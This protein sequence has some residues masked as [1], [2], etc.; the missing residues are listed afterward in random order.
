MNVFVAGASGAIGRPV[1]AEL[2][3]HRHNVT[4]LARSQSA[5]TDLRIQGVTVIE[6]DVFDPYSIRAAIEKARPDVVIDELTSLPKS[7]AELANAIP[8]DLKIRLEGGGNLHRAAEEF[9]VKRYLQQASGFFLKAAKGLADEGSPIAVEAGGNVGLSA[10]MYAE[11]E[12]RVRR[13]SMEGVALRYGFFYGPGT[14]YR[15]DGSAAEQVRRNETPIIGDGNAVWSFVHVEDAAMAT[16]AA[17]TAEPG[18]YNITDDNP[19][20]VIQWLPAFARWIGA[21]APPHV[22]VEQARASAGEDAVFYGTRLVGA[23]N[24]KA[25][26]QLG[27]RPRQLAWL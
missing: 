13:S 26:H 12:N 20:P 25:R 8:G 17:I 24:A 16:V 1:I 11:L 4:G 2:L 27:F 10:R 5:L 7:S 21:P 23:S 14:W 22:T 15:Q 18:V 19:S 9:G 3:R 6:A